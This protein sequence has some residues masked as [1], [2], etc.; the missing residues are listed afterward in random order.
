MAAVNFR[1]INKD[2]IV[3]IFGSRSLEWGKESSLVLEEINL[4]KFNMMIKL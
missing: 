3:G 2:V 1:K 4:D